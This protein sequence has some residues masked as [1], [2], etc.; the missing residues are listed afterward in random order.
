M[1]STI[2][3][4]TTYNSNKKLEFP[5]ALYALSTTNKSDTIFIFH[6]LLSRLSPEIERF[7]GVANVAFILSH[8]PIQKMFYIVT[9][10]LIPRCR[11]SNECSK[12][13]YLRHF[14]IN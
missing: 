7:Y 11:K 6:V 4:F 8:D 10:L 3:T 9:F 13:F 2:L 12:L 1:S 5:N 14:V